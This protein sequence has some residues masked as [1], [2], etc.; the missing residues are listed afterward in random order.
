MTYT[1]EYI[2]LEMSK[3]FSIIQR[4]QKMAGSYSLDQAAAHQF[5]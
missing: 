3:L 4:K 2:L 5:S 1:I